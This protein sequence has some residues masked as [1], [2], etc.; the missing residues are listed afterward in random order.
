MT[1]SALDLQSVV[2]K[3]SLDAN[4]P[5]HSDVLAPRALL[6]AAPPSSLA[7]V[8]ASTIGG[9]LDLVV[10]DLFRLMLPDKSVIGCTKGSLLSLNRS[11]RESVGDGG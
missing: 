8:T 6:L 2:H 10:F 4:E 7:V 1:T 3:E 9:A 11:R 5:F